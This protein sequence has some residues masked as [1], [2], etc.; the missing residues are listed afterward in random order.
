MGHASDH[1]GA[2]LPILPHLRQMSCVTERANAAY[3]ARG[4]GGFAGLHMR[5]F[6]IGAMPQPYLST[7]DRLRHSL[8][9]TE[10]LRGGVQRGAV[11]VVS[12]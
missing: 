11:R 1:A 4:K 6:E 9:T 10:V 5:D 8:A 12:L 3:D 2:F 7:S